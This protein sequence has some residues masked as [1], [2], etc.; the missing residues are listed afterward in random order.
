MTLTSGTVSRI[1]FNSVSKPLAE[2]SSSAKALQPR[3]ASTAVYSKIILFL[4]ISRNM[5]FVILFISVFF[6]EFGDSARNF[7]FAGLPGEFFNFFVEPDLSILHK[8]DV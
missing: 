5:N 2:L 3:I 8:N 1:M 7:C 4:S 6:Q